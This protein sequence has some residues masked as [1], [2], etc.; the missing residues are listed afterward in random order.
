MAK[1]YTDTKA[2]RAAKAAQSAMPIEK[3]N[4][5]VPEEVVEEDTA[6][7]VSFSQMEIEGVTSD[8]EP[9]V[10]AKVKKQKKLKKKKKEI[11]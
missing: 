9:E 10:V 3:K 8:V 7:A 1:F 6:P 2:Q 4:V 5:D 11:E